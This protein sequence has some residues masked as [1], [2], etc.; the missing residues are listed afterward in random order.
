MK[1][2]FILFTMVLLSFNLDAQE[3]AGNDTTTVFRVETIDGNIYTGVITEEDQQYITISTEKLG[4]IR[5][6]KS[7]VKSSTLLTGVRKEA[8]E[9]W[10]PN[11]QST[12]Y[13]W[14]PNGYGLNKG[15]AYYQNIWI[16]YNQFSWGITNNFSMSAGTIPLFLFAG[17]STPI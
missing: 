17:T 4:I 12:R 5:I 13:F 16:F 1:N 7:D 9:Y 15:E 3:F 2:L 11:P 14:A 8:G 10:L 6:S